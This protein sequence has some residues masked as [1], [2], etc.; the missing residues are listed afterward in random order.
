MKRF[1][2][3][4]YVSSALMMA[5]AQAGASGAQ[6][7]ALQSNTGTR[8]DS[9][10][11]VAFD[12]VPLD[13]AIRTIAQ[14]AGV[15]MM[16][17]A[18]TLPAKKVTYRA[19]DVSGITALTGVLRGTGVEIERAADGSLKLTV[20]RRAVK[21]NTQGGISGKITDAKTGK[22]IPG[23]NI[24]IGT[25]NR[26]TTT[27][28]DGSY[29]L[30]GISTGTYTVT[31]RLIGYAKQTRSVTVGEGATIAVD[32]KLEPS[33][34]VLNQVVVTGTVIA[35]ELK[36]VPSAITVITAKQIEARGITSIDQ[37]FRGE[38]P[39]L[40]AME[41]GAATLI[42]GTP[43]LNEVTLFSRGATRISS[44]GFASEMTN[45]IKTY[46]DGIELGDSRYLSQIDPR[47]IERIE[48]LTGPQASTIY[49]AN[50]INGVMQ[51]FTKRG[52]TAKPHISLS[53]LEGW[54]QNNFSSALSPSHQF[55][56]IV[57]GLEGKLSYNVGSGWDYTGAWTPGKQI[58]R[59][60]IFG[61]GQYQARAFN[62]DISARQ[63][64]TKNKVQG[65]PSQIETAL[66]ENGT[67]FRPGVAS[68]ITTAR[69][70]SLQ[71]RTLGLTV[72]YNP[73]SWWSHQVTVGSDISDT[74]VIGSNPSFAT[75]NDTSYDNSQSFNARTSQS[76]SSTLRLSVFQPVGLQISYG[77]DHWRNRTSFISWSKNLNGTMANPSVTRSRPDKN[78]G[79]F[80]Q[81]QL[82]V[83]DAL[84]FTY[85]LRADWNPNFG[86]NA[87][88]RPGRYGVSYTRDLETRFGLVSAKLR[89]AYGRSIEPPAQ[90]QIQ[91]MLY[92]SSDAATIEF[93]GIGLY[94]LLPSPDLGA[95]FQQGGEGGLEL[96]FGSR[97]S[98]VVTR[99]NQTV[100]RLIQP[101]SA[102][103]SVRAVEPGFAPLGNFV[104]F[105]F[106]GSGAEY[107]LR[108]DGYCYY[109][110]T[111][112]LNVGSIRNQGWEL[113]GSVN[114]GPIATSGSY[115]WNKS[116]VIGITPRYRSLV[117]GS[118]GA[119]ESFFAPGQTFNY[120]PEHTWAVNTSYS[121]SNTSVS[122]NVNGV[123]IIFRDAALSDLAPVTSLSL[124]LRG[125]N[126]YK[127]LR[128]GSDIPYREPVSG[129]VTANMNGLHR[130][131]MRV[132]ATLQ[133]TNLTDH[134][135]NDFSYQYPTIG[136]QFRVGA[137]WRWQ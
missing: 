120:A 29:R 25:D 99:Y 107:D 109:R 52:G 98:L 79:A 118:F 32:F 28:E 42:G 95:E 82:G 67:W 60:S 127:W 128:P 69:K 66:V 130:F 86:K 71:G 45:P 53:L 73:L 114:T 76:Y 58:Q 119:S 8:N 129:Y 13:E 39:G 3:R 91:G 27:S 54:T 34:N 49:G 102:V 104:S 94:D 74:E 30:T 23:A 33:V 38:I 92:P 70:A 43:S 50:A 108:S 133:I 17:S 87:K 47:S 44:S 24:S 19:K 62:A 111:Q 78:N 6:A 46:V 112:Y 20:P 18:S 63:G 22:N 116:R 16:F 131:T 10:I 1:C 75:R 125:Q 113:Q 68:G 123:G 31:V 136:R 88:V 124:R 80:V 36:A 7:I 81:G 35:T 48:I 105:C 115:S 122:L 85:G 89:G 26:G 5:V 126:S 65:L 21:G 84:F 41:T 90:G 106:P 110:Q 37:L 135:Q 4:W 40:F 61:A 137:R 93:Y 134:Y 64:W 51:I 59:T 132:E 100:D 96:Y 101:L 9:K 83:F 121:H 56:G 55:D 2:A 12:G 14:R 15:R 57:S 117:T 11:T 97:A 77:A 72:G 103:D